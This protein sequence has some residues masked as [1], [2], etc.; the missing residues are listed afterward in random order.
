MPAPQP[1]TCSSS[2]QQARDFPPPSTARSQ[3]DNGPLGQ[4]QWLLGTRTL[5]PGQKK[6]TAEATAWEQQLGRGQQASA[7]SSQ[8]TKSRE[9]KGEAARGAPPGF[10]GAGGARPVWG[11][12]VGG[13]PRGAGQET[14]TWSLPDRTW[15]CTTG[16]A[17]NRDQPVQLRGHPRDTCKVSR[18]S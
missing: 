6:T 2:C 13:C 16:S 3:G 17:A 7:E 5:L 12:G 1:H 15:D 14:C 10:A 9:T 4:R 11:E 8:P 18:G